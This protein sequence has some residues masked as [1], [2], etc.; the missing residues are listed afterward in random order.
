MD[1]VEPFLLGTCIEI[2]KAKRV[3]G[4][5]AGVMA[6]FIKR[7]FIDDKIDRFTFV[8]KRP[9][10]NTMWSAVITPCGE[11]EVVPP[12]FVMGMHVVGRIREADAWIKKGLG[13]KFDAQV[14][15]NGTCGFRNHLEGTNGVRTR[16]LPRPESRFLKHDAINKGWREAVV[17]G[18]TD[19]QQ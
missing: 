8:T 18:P 3:F 4:D 5:F 10:A 11:G 14:F 16:Y 12:A 2:G 13:V 9:R 6:R 19:L 17:H 15:G 1:D 7:E